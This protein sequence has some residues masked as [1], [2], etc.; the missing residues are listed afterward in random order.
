MLWIAE[1]E[2]GI[3]DQTVHRQA[4]VR[5]AGYEERKGPVDLTRA[6]GSN[7]RVVGSLHD[8]EREAGPVLGEALDCARQETRES[9]C[10]A[11]ACVP[12]DPVSKRP[13]LVERLLPIPKHEPRVPLEQRSIHRGGDSLAASREE[14]HAERLLQRSHPTA[15]SRLR[16]AS[17]FG[18]AEDASV[19]EDREELLEISYIHSAQYAVSAY[20]ARAFS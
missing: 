15:E 12:L 10:D 2:N 6:K 9:G 5:F 3:F 14:L 8:C 18:S 7:Q 11:H 19:L 1:D 16:H 17:L 13:Q 4:I 20:S